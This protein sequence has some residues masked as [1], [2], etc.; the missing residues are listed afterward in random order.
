[1]L[2][3]LR[4]GTSAPSREVLGAILHAFGE[5][6][7]V[8]DLVLHFLEHELAAERAV[9]LDGTSVAAGRS[10]DAL[11]PFGT[12]ARAELRAF[13]AHFLRRSLSSG[14]GLCIT[15]A[16]DAALR[17]AATYVRA[18][19][20][21]Q[22]LPPVV[23]TA[24]APLAASHRAS[25]LAA[26]LVIAER[27]DFASKPVRAVLRERVAVRKPVLLT[28]VRP[29]AEDADLAPVLRTT[30]TLSLSAPAPPTLPPHA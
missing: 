17:T 28:S 27:V 1:M 26:P 16:D 30:A 9:M 11:K 4:A 25:A 6:P 21:A 5:N 19:L 8:R 3:R 20:D 24:Q 22:G 23:L 7:H 10:E 18:A 14:R 2:N 15:A 13:V 29:L 12:R